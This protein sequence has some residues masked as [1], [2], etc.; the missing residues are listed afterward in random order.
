LQW[1]EPEEHGPSALVG[2]ER[3]FGFSNTVAART[4]SASGTCVAYRLRNVGF[5]VAQQVDLLPENTV[6]RRAGSCQ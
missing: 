2:L 6:P 5:L 1:I 4:P 3:Q